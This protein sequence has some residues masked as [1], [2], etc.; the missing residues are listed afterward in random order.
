MMQRVRRG[1]RTRRGTTIIYLGIVIPAVIAL[2]S[3]AVDYARVQIAKSQLRLTVD[4]AARAGAA[5]IP[6]GVT[7]AQNSVVAV[8]ASNNCDGAPVSIDSNLDI[9]FGTWSENARTFTVLSGVSRANANALRVFGRRTAA[10][11]N[12]IPLTFGPI[13][14][15]QNCNV[16]VSCIAMYS[17]TP[18][19]YGVIALSK[20]DIKGNVDSYDSGNG[21]WTAVSATSNGSVACNTDIKM[22]GTSVIHGDA[23]YGTGY[24]VNGGSVTGSASALSTPVTAPAATAGNAATSNDDANLPGGYFNGTDFVMNGGS[25]TLP[26]G[27]YYIGKFTLNSGAVVNITA[28][29]TIYV[30]GAMAMTGAAQLNANGRP[31]DLKLTILGSNGLAMSGTTWMNAIVYA[32]GTKVAMS[33]TATICGAIVCDEIKDSGSSQFHVDEALHLGSTPNPKVT[34]VK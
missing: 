26:A 15:A 7:S 10:R 32:P 25:C 22:G 9:D 17:Q 14:G 5:S 19:T 30:N 33:N 34:L 29:T 13:V 21:Q 3:F 27:T 6:S 16:T 12:P 1:I 24:M 31:Q 18:A 4:A 2:A 20:F 8:A 11:S 28:P 23:H